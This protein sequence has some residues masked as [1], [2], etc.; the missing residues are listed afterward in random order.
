MQELWRG[1][2]LALKREDK[3]AGEA[4]TMAFS[5]IE[6]ALGVAFTY[7]QY[8]G[9]GVEAYMKQVDTTR[10]LDDARPQDSADFLPLRTLFHSP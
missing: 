5:C 2:V 10:P 1:E 8:C 7:S 3:T 9:R 6:M 4:K